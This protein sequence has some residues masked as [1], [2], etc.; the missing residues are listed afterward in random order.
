MY[1]QSATERKKGRNIIQ[2]KSS[3]I[4]SIRRLFILCQIMFCIDSTCYLPFY[5]LIADL[6]DS[7]GVSVELIKILNRLGVCVS[8]D[9]LLRHI[10]QKVQEGI[11]QGLNPSILTLFTLLDDIDLYIAMPKYLPETR[12]L[13]GMVQLSR[14]CKPSL[15]N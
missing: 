8:N 2:S 14:L 11:L 6:I 4:K 13:V 7:Y 12:L 10:Q 1:S 3:K 9:T 15:P 5:V